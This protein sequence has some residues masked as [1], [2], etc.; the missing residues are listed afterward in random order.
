MRGFRHY[1]ERLLVLSLLFSFSSGFTMCKKTGSVASVEGSQ[2]VV[3]STT[4]SGDST[5]TTDSSGTSTGSSDSHSNAVAPKVLSFSPTTESVLGGS[6]LSIVGSDLSGTPAVSVGGVTCTQPTLVSSSL[7][8]CTLPQA[9]PG[10]VDVSVSLASVSYPLS[11]KLTYLGVN[12][13]VSYSSAF[14]QVDLFAG[15]RMQLGNYDGVGGLARFSNPYGLASDGTYLYVG[16]DYSSRVRKVNIA[17]HEVT[18]LANVTYPRSVALVGSDLYITKYGVPG[19]YKW[20]GTSFNLVVGSASTQGYVDGNGTSARFGTLDRLTS[21]GSNYLYAAEYYYTNSSSYYRI[22]RIAVNDGG[23]YAVSTIAGSVSGSVDGD[24][25]G[26]G[27]LARFYGIGGLALSGSNLYV[28]DL[29]NASIRKVDLGG[30]N[31]PVTTVAG[32][33][34]QS[35]TTDGVGSVA[36]FNQPMAMARFANNLYVYD[37]GYSQKKIRLIDLTTYAVS[38]LPVG[39]ASSWSDGDG[40]IAS[41]PNVTAMVAS[42]DGSKLY[43]VDNSMSNIRSIALG[44]SFTVATIAGPVSGTAGVSEVTNAT[45]AAAKFGNIEGMSSDGTALY[46]SD[47]GAYGIRKAILATGEVSTIVGGTYVSNSV[48]GNGLGAGIEWPGVSTAS[49]NR[50]YFADRNQIRQVDLS[51]SSYAVTTLAGTSGYSGYGYVDGIGSAAKFYAPGGLAKV[52]NYLFVADSGNHTIRRILL[53]DHSSGTTSDYSVVTVAGTS[54]TVGSTNGT[55][56]NS[57]FY[58][59]AGLIAHGQYLYIADMYNSKIRKLNL[60]DSLFTVSDVATLSSYPKSISTDGTYLYVPEINGSI[61]KVRLSD[62]AVSSFAGSSSYSMDS[63]D[64]GALSSAYFYLTGSAYSV[65]TSFG[66]FIGNNYGIREIH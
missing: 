8:T 62:A 46:L 27:T 63:G 22:R 52:G 57:L 12:E 18:T 13:A 65:V 40:V 20:N 60:S 55:G 16:D 26:G 25:T 6:V 61:Q 42:A 9:V 50:L 31:F 7:I 39:G 1:F 45:G 14:S 15:S 3:D 59:P 41:F 24:G 53:G 30:A 17:T 19:V 43:V 48:D 37:S 56:L 64:A 5:S 47:T 36:R 28:A 51:N 66:L 32:S 54:G 58:G 34:G 49:Q 35:G 23:T 44:S 10:E 21:D 29:Y 33:L 11:T 38:T 4:G 2:P